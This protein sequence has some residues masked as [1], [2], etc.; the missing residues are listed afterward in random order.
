MLFLRGGFRGLLDAVLAVEAFHAPRGIDQ[1][2]LAGVKRMT[3]RAHLDVKLACGRASLEGISA[4]ARHYASMVFGMDCSFHLS[5]SLRSPDRYHR[6]DNHTIRWVN[7]R[8]HPVTAICRPCTIFAVLAA[9]G[10]RMR[11]P[12]R[13][14]AS[15]LRLSLRRIRTVRR[16]P[17]SR[18]FWNWHRPDR[19]APSAR[20]RRSIGSYIF[21]IRHCI[22]SIAPRWSDLFDQIPPRNS[23]LIR[24]ASMYSRTR[25]PVDRILMEHMN[26]A[27]KGY[28]SGE[29]SLRHHLAF[30]RQC[31]TEPFRLGAYFALK[32]PPE[33]ARTLVL[34]GSRSSGLSAAKSEPILSASVPSS[35]PS[36]RSLTEVYGDLAPPWDTAPGVVQSS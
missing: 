15:A 26:F 32:P 35:M 10:V 17:T 12:G 4:C 28:P 11:R 34:D 20:W 5:S 36:R 6:K 22:R 29:K 24:A 23:T 25:Y 13:S 9:I 19:I 1:P 21:N 3:V 16:A 30:L 33:I 18:R 7:G 2:L 14:Y 27:R 31:R 8:S